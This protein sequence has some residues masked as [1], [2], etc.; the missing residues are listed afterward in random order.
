MFIC[1]YAYAHAGCVQ[2]PAARCRWPQP[3]QYD[4]QIWTGICNNNHN[5]MGGSTNQNMIQTDASLTS[6]KS[7]CTCILSSSPSH[8]EDC[9]RLLR[10]SHPCPR[11]RAKLRCTSNSVVRAITRIAPSQSSPPSSLQP[12]QSPSSSSSSEPCL[13][14]LEGK[15][16]IL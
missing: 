16:P 11:T 8:S 13:E 2:E 1:K 3:Q 9:D 14:T 4:G 7:E 15:G 5:D 12:S 10:K 6:A